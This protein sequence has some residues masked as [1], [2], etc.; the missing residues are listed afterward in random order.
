M[1]LSTMIYREQYFDAD[2]DK[3]SPSIERNQF[4]DIYVLLDFVL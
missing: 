3:A 4:T 1:L 2:L